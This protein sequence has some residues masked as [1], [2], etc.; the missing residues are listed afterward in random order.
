MPLLSLRHY[1]ID[2][3][4]VALLFVSGSLDVLA[5]KEA[6]VYRE[7]ALN[8]VSMKSREDQYTHACG[9]R[10]PGSGA[11]GYRKPMAQRAVIHASAGTQLGRLYDSFVR[12]SDRALAVAPSLAIQR[13]RFRTPLDER[14]RL[15]RAGSHSRRDWPIRNGWASASCSVD[16]RRGI[17]AIGSLFHVHSRMG[18]SMRK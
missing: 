10:S 17:P 1:P 15:H 3:R 12:G 8:P 13:S 2:E 9:D 7:R 14:L 4:V 18:S 16:H 11:G 5:E 6:A